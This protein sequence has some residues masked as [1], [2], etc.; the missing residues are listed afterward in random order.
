MTLVKTILLK[1]CFKDMLLQNFS[2]IGVQEQSDVENIV[3]ISPEGMCHM[4]QD[5]FNLNKSQ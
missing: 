4:L 2:E 1:T 5:A 3:L